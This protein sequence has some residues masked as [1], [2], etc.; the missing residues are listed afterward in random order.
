MLGELEY[1]AAIGALALEHCARVM[2]P[3]RQHMYLGFLPRHELAVEPNDSVSLVERNDGHR[4][5]SSS[6]AGKFRALQPLHAKPPSA[7]IMPEASAASRWQVEEGQR[8]PR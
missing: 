4:M 6:W 2:Q 7:Y 1:L 3:M 5:R 8:T